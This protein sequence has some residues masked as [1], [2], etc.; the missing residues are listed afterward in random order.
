M[1]KAFARSYISEQQS[2][3]ICA[4]IR[5]QLRIACDEEMRVQAQ[6]IVLDEYKPHRVSFG[7]NLIVFSGFPSGSNVIDGFEIENLEYG[8]GH[9]QPIFVNDRATVLLLPDTADKQA[10][11]LK[12]YYEMNHKEQK[13]R[14]FFFVLYTVRAN[15]EPKQ[16]DLIC[17]IDSEQSLYSETLYAYNGQLMKKAS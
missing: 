15:G 14:L 5:N 16:I 1:D 8:Q 7:R 6:R 9:H 13:S 2:E 17:P 4:I 12:K 10:K 11:Y 3:Q